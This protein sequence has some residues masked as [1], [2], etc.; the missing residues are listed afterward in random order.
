MRKE[1][2][3]NYYSQASEGIL[4]FLLERDA[5]IKQ[6]SDGELIFR[7]Y[8]RGKEKIRIRSKGD[9]LNWVE[10]GALGIYGY[11][12]R[13]NKIKDFVIDIDRHLLPLEL[14]KQVALVVYEILKERYKIEPAVKFSGNAGFHLMFYVD[15]KKLRLPPGIDLWK[16]YRRVVQFLR[17]KAEQKIQRDKR[18][19]KK[20]AQI[21]GAVTDTTSKLKSYQKKILMDRSVNRKNGVIRAPYSLHEKTFLVAIP[22]RPDELRNFDE[23]MAQSK[24]ALKRMKR[25]SYVIPKASPKIIE[26]ALE[27]GSLSKLWEG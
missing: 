18:L 12:E 5:A 25:V 23:R 17:D 10:R 3:A 13:E 11:L 1:E 26:D 8:A 27:T 15:E 20:F 16:A 2:I 6:R 19:R 9:L 14:A 24:K 21:S 7:R 4:E 22:L